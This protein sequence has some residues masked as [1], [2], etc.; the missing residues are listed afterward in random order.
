M[1]MICVISIFLVHSTGVLLVVC[2]AFAIM[3]TSISVSS[4]PL[5]MSLSNY[6]D[7]VFCVGVFFSGVAVPSGIL[8]AV[9]AF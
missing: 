6:Y 9:Q 8:E 7:K 3:F 2:V 5:A 4:L 1:I